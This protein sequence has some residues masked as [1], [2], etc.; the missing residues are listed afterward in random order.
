MASD[1]V[2]QK[3]TENS[4]LFKFWC[5]HKINVEDYKSIQVSKRQMERTAGEDPDAKSKVT[6]TMAQEL[7]DKGATTGMPAPTSDRDRPSLHT[8]SRVQA[9]FERLVGEDVMP[10]YVDRLARTAAVGIAPLQ[11][12]SGASVL[13]TAMEG[14]YMQIRT[15]SGIFWKYFKTVNL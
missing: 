1:F 6:L 4:N 12:L 13:A 10:G 8:L 15:F 11:A 5:W 9:A 7:E 14:P 3:F 2:S